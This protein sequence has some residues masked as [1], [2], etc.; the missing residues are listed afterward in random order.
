MRVIATMC[1]RRLIRRHAEGNHFC[2][3]VVTRNEVMKPKANAK[4]LLFTFSHF[5]TECIHNMQSTVSSFLFFILV[6]HFVGFFFYYAIHCA[7]VSPERVETQ[8]N[9]D[10]VH[11]QRKKQHTNRS[12]TADGARVKTFAIGLG[13]QKFGK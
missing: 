8:R 5:S 13:Q 3:G 12:A 7:S 11:E 1:R 4:S 2:C 10:E 6:F 9:E